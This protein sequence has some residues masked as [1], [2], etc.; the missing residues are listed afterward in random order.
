MA[1][2]LVAGSASAAPLLQ[3]VLANPDDHHWEN[4]TNNPGGNKKPGIWERHCLNVWGL[5]Y[6]IGDTQDGSGI[7]GYLGQ[8][9]VLPNS[10][11]NA[12]GRGWNTDWWAQNN[13]EPQQGPRDPAEEYLIYD[14]GEVKSLGNAYLWNF[15]SNV[16]VKDFLLKVSLDADPNTATWTAAGGGALVLPSG[17]DTPAEVFAMNV[18]ARLVMLD[19]Q[20]AWH[21]NGWAGLGEIAFSEGTGEVP[22]PEPA[23]LGLIGLALVAVRK[24][25]S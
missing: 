18:D 15:G 14:L 21:P 7:V 10:M 16:A 6:D 4:A 8:T 9:E 13:G 25:R 17:A 11:H 19:I 5:D 20:S 3:G 1:V 2:V 24:R 12:S 22:I 23:G